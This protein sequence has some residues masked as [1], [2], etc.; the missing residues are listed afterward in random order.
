MVTWTRCENLTAYSFFRNF[1]GIMLHLQNEV[2]LILY[3]RQNYDIWYLLLLT[4]CCAYNS[5][6]SLTFYLGGTV[7]FIFNWQILLQLFSIF[8][9][10]FKMLNFILLPL[11]FTIVF[12]GKV[13]DDS[14]LD[15]AITRSTKLWAE[16]NRGLLMIPVLTRLADAPLYTAPQIPELMEAGTHIWLLHGLKHM[17]S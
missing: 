10:V 14:E 13:L 4:F 5:W 8:F 17:V 15:Y 16:G 12:P 3:F 6:H 7:R 1:Q 9:N 2:A 11:F